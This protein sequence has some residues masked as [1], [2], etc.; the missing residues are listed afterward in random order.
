MFQLTTDRFLSDLFTWNYFII[1]WLNHKKAVILYKP[2]SNSSFLWTMR[3]AT[4]SVSS[5]STYYY[6]YTTYLNINGFGIV[7]S[8][9]MTVSVSSDCYKVVYFTITSLTPGGFWEKGLNC[10]HKSVH[11]CAQCFSIWTK[12]AIWGKSH[13]LLQRLSPM[14]FSWIFF[15]WRNPWSK[16]KLSKDFDFSQH[17]GDCNSYF[18]NTFFIA[19]FFQVLS[20]LCFYTPVLTWS[21]NNWLASLSTAWC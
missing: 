3:C 20:A 4:T 14:F 2:A 8:G 7:L 17:W 13:W 6:C 16:E 12:S 21:T 1:W 9:G 18:V 10:V 11:T 5:S 15:K 19:W